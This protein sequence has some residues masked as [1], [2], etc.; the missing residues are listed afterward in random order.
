M[1]ATADMVAKLGAEN[2]RLRAD[3]GRVQMERDRL[4]RALYLCQQLFQEAFDGWQGA[5]NEAKLLRDRLA[6]AEVWG[7]VREAAAE[8]GHGLRTMEGR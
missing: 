7:E 3:L 5:V 4:D 6:D 1:S 8:M 2:A